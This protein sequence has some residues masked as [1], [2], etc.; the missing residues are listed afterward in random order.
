MGLI[1]KAAGKGKRVVGDLTGN[2]ALKQEGVEQERQADQQQATATERTAAM[3]TQ[4][5]G[6]GAQEAPV[7]NTI[8][9]LVQTL[10]VKLDSSYRYGLYQEDA[11]KDGYEDCAQVFGDIAERERETID[12]LLR[13]LHKHIG[14]A[15]PSGGAAAGVSP[16]AGAATAEPGVAGPPGSAGGVA[17]EPTGAAS[18]VGAERPTTPTQ[19]PA[20]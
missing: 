1:D 16:A 7:N 9:N 10:S 19:P 3:S 11:V 4:Q 18:A 15:A 14:D 8:H 20:P 5:R 12:R 6:S 17:S 13:C 2:E